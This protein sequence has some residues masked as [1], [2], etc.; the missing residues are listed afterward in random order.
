VRCPE[1]RPISSLVRP[2]GHTTT[3]EIAKSDVSCETCPSLTNSDTS[4]RPPGAMPTSTPFTSF[5]CD[6]ALVPHMITQSVSALTLV[7]IAV[8]HP[9]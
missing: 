9:S 3:S 5:S 2:R 6:P 8:F 1:T 4:P 7:G